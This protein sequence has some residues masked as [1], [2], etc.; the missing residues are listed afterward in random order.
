[1]VKR[2][3]VVAAVVLIGWSAAIE[4]RLVYLQVARH[5][6]LA[7][8]AERQQLRTVET[9]AERGDILD[10]NGRVFAFSVDADSIYA[11]PTDIADP[12]AA[13]AALCRA[14]DDCN[15]R[16][17]QA[18]ADRIRRGRAFAYVRR[19]VSPGEARRIAALALDGIGFMS[20]SRRFYPNKELA[21]HV[22][23]YV[24]IDNVGLNGLEAAYDSLIKGR[25]G[26]VLVQ[27]DARRQAFSRIERPPTSG[28]TLELTIDQQLQHVA[29]RE[30]RAGVEQAGAAGGSVVVM[31]PTTGE[32][33]A[34]A[35]APTFNPNAYRE[36]RDDDRR[37]RAV[38]DLY[39][40]GSTFKIVT[41]G[42]ALEEGLFGPDSPV[43]TSPGRIWFGSRVIDEDRGHN[44]GRLSFTDVI[45]KSSNVGAVKVGLRLGPERLGQYVQ[46][47]GFGRRSSP[48]FPGESP[49]IV[50]NPARLTDSALASVAMGYQVGVTPLQMAAAASVVANGGE[51]IEPRIV[52]AVIADGVRT[53]VPRKVARRVVSPGTAALL[54]D[55]MEQV[56]ER[57]TGTRARV[58]G[59]TVAGK[60]GTAQKVV[61]GR[62]ST[63]DYNVS[64][65]G[66]VPSRQ[67]V[68]AI[69][70]VVD[71][72]H[73]VAPYGGTVAAPIFQRLAEAG[74][75]LYGVPPSLNPSPPVVVARR[76]QTSRQPASGPATVPAIVTLE[77]GATGTA[78]L[79][80][81]LRGLGARDALRMLAR[82]GL[83]A[84]LHGTGIVVD[85]DPLPGSPIERGAV[86][87]L[88]LER[89]AGTG[90]LVSAAAAPGGGP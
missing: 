60:T 31:D 17:R 72:P 63:T 1:M 73:A 29:E 65:V 62:Y 74:L 41:A 82:L 37:N 18:I 52:R 53:A 43:E 25:P 59:F 56:V 16:E 7:A 3:L 20:E 61:G 32:I 67:P 66:F 24:G 50:W 85:Q 70:V 12:G 42:A 51:L 87:T 35:N 6:D 64:F 2:R 79:F 83:T 54:T 89:H 84:R 46:R 40:P 55:M 45:V 78:P 14:L 47:F 22:L 28:A 44:Y 48:D 4:A 71:S 13:A 81:D 86:S 68:L 15:A 90:T 10:R 23:G 27:T 75:R 77:G 88:R 36:Y 26:A 69:V 5:A 80:P 19:Q 39:E 76:E 58:P 33:L 38:Q 57:G 21:A 8:R 9:A 30:L 49:G 11:V 34:L